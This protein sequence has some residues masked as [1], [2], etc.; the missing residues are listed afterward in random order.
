[1]APVPQGKHRFVEDVS[2][3]QVVI[4]ESVLTFTPPLRVS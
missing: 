1:M 2:G 4:V 3:T